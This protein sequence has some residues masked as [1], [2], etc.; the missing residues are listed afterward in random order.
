MVM[1]T[2]GVT[3]AINEIYSG[4]SDGALKEW[5]AVADKQLQELISLVRGKLSRL[6]RQMLGALI[7]LDVHAQYVVNILIK[8]QIT[9]LNDFNWTS[10]LRYYWEDI[11]DTDGDPYKGDTDLKDC[12]CK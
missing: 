12:F 4:V 6:D 2:K 5:Q 10:Q 3:E 9:S 8:S 1:W 7:V 11:Q